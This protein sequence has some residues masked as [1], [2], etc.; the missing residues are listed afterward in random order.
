MSS[1]CY[2]V[3]GFCGS[4]WILETRHGEGERE[5]AVAEARSL[6]GSRSVDAAKVIEEDYDEH[7]G[8]C[9]E[10]TIFSTRPQRLRASIS[11]ITLP[12]E[13][14]A[15]PEETALAVLARRQALA[16][17]RLSKAPRSKG[18][19]V[20]YTKLLAIVGASLGVATGTTFLFLNM[21]V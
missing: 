18:A 1:V 4:R 7:S 14:A 11:H 15:A 12:R 17:L 20:L 16:E 3:Y 13:R 10:R 8:V 2:E 19:A 9:R 6:A 21:A 5:A